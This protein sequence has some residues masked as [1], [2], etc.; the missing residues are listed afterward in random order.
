MNEEQKGKTDG[1]MH[2]T[3][4][5]FGPGAGGSLVSRR[6]EDHSGVDRAIKGRP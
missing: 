3:L 1:T 6:P 2:K 4:S 5:I